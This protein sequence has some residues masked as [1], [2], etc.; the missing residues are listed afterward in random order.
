METVGLGSEMKWVRIRQMTWTEV[1]TRVSQEV[2]KR[3][4]L[5]WYRAGFRPSIEIR[6]GGAPANFF[7]SE[8]ELAERADLLRRHLPSEVDAIFQEADGVCRHQFQLL[9]YQPIDYGPSIDWHCDPIHGKRSPLLP[10][11]RIPYLDFAVV[12]DHKIV[13]ELNRHQHLL[14]LAKAWVLSGNGR[15]AKECAAQLYAWQRENPYP[16][17]INWASTL[18]VAFRSVSWLWIRL[19]LAHCPEL[20]AQFQIDLLQGLQV[21]GCHIERYLSTYFSPNTHLLGEAFALFFLGTLC[22]QVAASTRWRQKGWKILV[23]E[24][25]R[26]VRPDGVYFEQSLFYHVYALDFFLHAR[27]LAAKN[28]FSVPESFDNVIKKMLDVIQ[29]LSAT[30]PPEGFGDDDGGRL[31]NPRRNR[32]EHMTD[33]LALGAVLYRPEEYTSA[34]LTEEALWLFGQ[35]A[36]HVLTNKQS[37]G[38]VAAKAFEAGGIYLINDDHPCPQQMAIDAGPHGSG[39]AGHSHADAL[40][41]HYS[42]NRHRCLIDA[43]TYSY[44]CDPEERDRFRGTGAHNTLR[45]DDLDQAIATGPF[46]WRSLPKVKAETWL[47]GRTFDFFV[48][49]HEGYSRLPEPVIHRRFVFHVRGG[50]W[51][52][53]DVAA[54]EGRHRLETSWHFAPDLRLRKQAGIVI[55]ES[56]PDNNTEPRL[57]CL[58]LDQDSPWTM[59]ITDGFVSPAYGL[60][61]PAP[62]VR[63]STDVILPS[64][65]ALLL[66]PISEGSEPGML[67]AI[68]AS[69]A[70]QARAYRYQTKRSARFVFFASGAG[71]WTSSNWRSDAEFVYCKLEKRRFTHVIMIGGSF[72][73]WRGRKFISHPS[74]I[75]TFEWASD[76][77]TED[78]TMSGN[79]SEPGMIDDFE[80]FDPVV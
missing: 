30:G 75:E 63:I 41:I 24:S 29:A 4:D 69:S 19:L 14:T 55:A 26:Q 34:P 67:T 20:G 72:A 43:G 10:W 37:A 21:H 22:P 50:F 73:E 2:S 39:N 11:F 13:W 42:L 16:L 58:L 5:A 9:G 1:R 49:S 71:P 77:G 15:Y 68:N 80:V 32:I 53:R 45:V 38:C 74:R 28:G 52:V 27:V 18:E 56:A 51:F 35:R 54:G 76:S 6:H 3:F 36:T 57:F 17:G 40:S 59:Q 78:P 62:I 33:P 48:G 44:I 66:L 61:Q 25:E 23:E 65:C 8:S 31:F 47:N 70:D 7:F 12:G 79:R 60:K 46:A 64:D